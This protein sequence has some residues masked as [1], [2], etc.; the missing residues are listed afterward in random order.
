M[1]VEKCRI[2]RGSWLSRLLQFGVCRDCSTH[3]VISKCEP[4]KP[5]PDPTP[6]PRS[7]KK[8]PDPSRRKNRSGQVMRRGYGWAARIKAPSGRKMVRLPA[9]TRKEAVKL[10]RQATLKA[11]DPSYQPP[12][13]RPASPALLR[14][15]HN[16]KGIRWD[17]MPLGMVWD[18]LLAKHLCVTATVVSKQ[19]CKRGILPFVMRCVC[20]CGRRYRR[21]RHDQWA[22]SGE[23]AAHQIPPLLQELDMNLAKAATVLVELKREIRREKCGK[24]HATS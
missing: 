4:A 22:C 7:R 10:A 1:S 11:W 21:K 24:R 20:P 19:R 12:K 14:L 5:K 18:H 9:T 3:H 6:K 16:A 15:A 13:P 17:E 2:C 23:C 8:K